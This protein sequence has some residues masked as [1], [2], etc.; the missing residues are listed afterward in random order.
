[1]SS[2]SAA[3]SY[4]IAGLQTSQA[5]VANAASNIANNVNDQAFDNAQQ[6]INAQTATQDFQAN[7]NV[8]SLANQIQGSLINILA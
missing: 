4:A 8:L 1:M 6:L 5:K 2:I 7:A 3:A